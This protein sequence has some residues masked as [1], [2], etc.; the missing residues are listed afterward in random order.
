MATVWSILIVENHT[1]ET[2]KD[3][4]FIIVYGALLGCT[5]NLSRKSWREHCRNLHEPLSF[6]AEPN[7]DHSIKV[8]WFFIA[9]KK[10]E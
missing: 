1:C 7:Y 2:T 10:L 4:G 5:H 3:G 9:Y 6:F 8:V